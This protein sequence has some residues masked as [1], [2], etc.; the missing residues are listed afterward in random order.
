MVGNDK[1]TINKTKMNLNLREFLATGHFVGKVNEAFEQK[2]I[3]EI[4]QDSKILEHLSYIGQLLK[5]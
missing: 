5:K 3:S 1:S 4:Y 2:H